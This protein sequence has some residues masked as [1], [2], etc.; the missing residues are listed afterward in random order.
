MVGWLAELGSLRMPAD[1]AADTVW[2]I[3]S[4][5]IFRL[6]TGNRGWSSSEF[7]EWLHH[8]LVGLLVGGD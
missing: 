6:L 2:A 7:E 3:A 4:P 8:S 5:E 1:Q